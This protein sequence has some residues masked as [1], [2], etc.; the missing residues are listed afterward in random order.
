M[1]HTFIFDLD[2][3]T[4]DS[5]HRLG[6]GSLAS[7]RRNN[8]VANIMRDSMLPLAAT[9]RRG[10]AES[11]DVVICTSRVIGH[12]DRVWLNQRGMLPTTGNFIARAANDNRA[13]GIY[14]LS[15]LKRLAKSRGT[16]W[17]D[18]IKRIIFW[19]DDIDVQQTMHDAG[20]RCL[21]PVNYNLK[22]LEGAA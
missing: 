17:S 12:A 10:I 13:A 21:D 7:W 22:S 8:T 1:P 9:M 14:K 6:A 4:V 2:G 19:D 3:T 18:F 20:I 11:L 16:V 5:S 15:K